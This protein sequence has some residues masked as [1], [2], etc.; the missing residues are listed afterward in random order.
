MWLL[1]KGIRTEG[2]MA[3]EIPLAAQRPA[4]FVFA[5]HVEDRVSELS[6]AAAAV[7]APTSRGST[8]LSVR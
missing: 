6:R 1:L 7:S 8:R 5:S 3:P 4:E 2:P